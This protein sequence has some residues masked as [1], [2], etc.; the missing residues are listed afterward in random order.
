[1]I[2]FAR[3]CRFGP[4]PEGRLLLVRQ[5]SDMAPHTGLLL[6]AGGEFQRFL[7]MRARHPRS[8]TSA[9]VHSTLLRSLIIS[10]RLL[11][12]FGGCAS[13]S[14]ALCSTVTAVRLSTDASCADAH[15]CFPY[16]TLSSS[17][18]R[19]DSLRV[20]RAN[21]HGVSIP[22]GPLRSLAGHLALHAHVHDAS[23]RART[24]DR[25]PACRSP[26]RRRTAITWSAVDAALF[27]PWWR[28]QVA[29]VRSLSRAIC[30]ALSSMPSAGLAR[31]GARA[32]VG[33]CSWT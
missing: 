26:E 23:R 5:L 16:H 9:A 33:A 18:W 7:G 29:G 32:A 17:S 11:V 19:F 8:L 24:A 15:A 6:P 28:S 22:V 12:P 1:M 31:S 27:V 30:S 21:N 25:A 13:A 2:P 20:H 10:L 14:A 3:T 4:Y